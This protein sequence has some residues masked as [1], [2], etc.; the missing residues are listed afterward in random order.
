LTTTWDGRA[1]RENLQT[2]TIPMFM[3]QKSITELRI[4]P[5]H[6]HPARD[7]IQQEAESCGQLWARL[8]D[9]E[10]RTMMYD[11]LATPLLVE[12]SMFT[13]SPIRPEEQSVS[14]EFRNVWFKI[15]KH[16]SEV[17]WL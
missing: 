12:R 2:R 13:M 6:L 17:E 10:P 3:G 7:I 14:I 4:I 1:F 11:G 9:G 16:R 5:L 8:Y 15:N